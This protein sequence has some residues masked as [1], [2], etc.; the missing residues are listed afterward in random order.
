MKVLKKEKAF[1]KLFKFMQKIYKKHRVKRTRIMAEH[2]DKITK[3]TVSFELENGQKQSEVFVRQKDSEELIEKLSSLEESIK[4][5]DSSSKDHLDKLSKEF[6]DKEKR[7]KDELS[8][9]EKELTE[10]KTEYKKKQEELESSLKQR[11]KELDDTI[12]FAKLKKKELDELKTSLAQ[13]EK[14]LETKNKSLKDQEAKFKE[15]EKEANVSLYEDY[16]SL[17]SDFRKRFSYINDESLFS[18]NATAFARV[19]LG[20]LHEYIKEDLKNKR[21]VT[22]LIKFFDELFSFHQK[23]YGFERLKCV[24]GDSFNQK[25]QMNL[26]TKA[27]GNIKEVYFLGF[28]DKNQTYACIV[29]L[30]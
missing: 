14:E 17:P 27:Q 10:L 3:L 1:M 30:D 22:H 21:E 28:K 15:L 23:I 6:N 8:S 9:K 11:E 26:G 13:K 7:L 12:N 18:F 4:G 25:E 2:K 5:L 24:V 16:K 29:N 20:S 19:I